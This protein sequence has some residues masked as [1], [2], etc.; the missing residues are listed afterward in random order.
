MSLHRN[1]RPIARANSVS[2]F[3]CGDPKCRRVHVMLEDERGDGF[4]HFVVP[5][6]FIEALQKALYRA[7]VL[8]EEE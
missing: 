5:D 1:G 4:A 3:M 6:N 8:R 2:L 7:A